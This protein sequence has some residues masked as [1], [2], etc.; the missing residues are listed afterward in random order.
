VIGAAPSAKQTF[1][2]GLA[3]SIAARLELRQQ[4]SRRFVSLSPTLRQGVKWKPF[5]DGFPVQAS[6]VFDR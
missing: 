5:G 1:Q 6:L 2:M 4:M 3:T